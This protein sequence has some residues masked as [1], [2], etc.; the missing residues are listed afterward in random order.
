[1]QQS[2]FMDV[3]LA[4]LVPG[5]FAHRQE[6]LTLYYEPRTTQQ[7]PGSPPNNTKTG[8]RTPHAVMQGLMLLMMG[9]IARNMSS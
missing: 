7:P 3:P 6:Q 8:C 4:R 5:D 2:D 9:E 1:M